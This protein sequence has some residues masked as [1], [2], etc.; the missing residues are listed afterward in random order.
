MDG[1][2][3][4]GLKSEVYVHI[5]EN[6]VLA[7]DTNQKKCRISKD[8]WVINLIKAAEEDS[9]LGCV[10]IDENWQMPSVQK[11][12]RL[13]CK[14]EM[15]VIFPYYKEKERP[16]VLRPLLSL[17]KDVD[18][19]KDEKVMPLYWGGN[20][21]HFLNSLSIYLN[22]NCSS[23]CHRCKDYCKQFPFCTN[24]VGKMGC[25]ITPQMLELVLS[26]LNGFPLKTINVFGGDIYDGELLNLLENATKQ[27]SF[28]FRFYVYY[29]NFRTQTFV[30]SQEVH[31][32]IPADFNTGHLAAICSQLKN[33]NKILHFVIENE[34]NIQSVKEFISKN[35]IVSYNIH[36]F[37]TGDN[38]AFFKENV[39]MSESE[40][41]NIKLSMREI[42]RNQKLNANY[43]GVLCIMPDGSIK[44]KIDRQTLGY[45]GENELVD[46]IYKELITNSAWRNIRDGEPCSK[47]LFQYL[48]PPPSDYETI[49]GK[50]N[51][52]YLRN[53]KFNV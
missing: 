1:Y 13:T 23:G 36:P 38:E 42:F 30:D 7:Y 2:F 43:F 28:C 8:K 24:Y 51:L 25:S 53:N 10:L 41:V 26:E 46:I 32:L 14:D 31:L 12:I 48:C 17:N 15:A 44:T 9:A 39:Y 47:C 5:C 22:S 27:Y 35:G 45:V 11:W 6:K 49:I 3:W 20:V 33:N 16:V 29:E 18:K 4:Y 34:E 40:L 21:K 19:I 37:Y 50:N 52:C